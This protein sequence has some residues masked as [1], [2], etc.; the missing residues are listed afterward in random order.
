MAGQTGGGEAGGPSLYPGPTGDTTTAVG[1]GVL[2]EIEGLAGVTV[3][4]GGPPLLFNPPRPPSNHPPF[5]SETS[6]F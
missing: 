6:G 5:S 2:E 1:L 4:Q 3:Y